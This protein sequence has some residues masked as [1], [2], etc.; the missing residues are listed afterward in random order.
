MHNTPLP[1]PTSSTVRPTPTWYSASNTPAFA[2]TSATKW[3]PSAPTQPTM[4]A[5]PVVAKAKPSNDGPRLPKRRKLDSEEEK[6]KDHTASAVSLSLFSDH[7]M[8]LYPDADAPFVD[9]MDVVS[10]LLPYHIFQHPKEDLE[11]VSN[12]KGKG[13]MTDELPDRDE[14]LGTKLAMKC[15]KRRQAL[16]E[17]F[18]RV[19][20]RAGKHNEP[21]DQAITLANAILDADRSATTYMEQQLNMA[22]SELDR[23]HKA[24][25]AASAHTHKGQSSSTT[26]PTFIT[27]PFGGNSSYPRGPPQGYPAYYNAYTYPYGQSNPYAPQA[28]T[29]TGKS[30]T[31]IANKTSSFVTTWNSASSST[32][33]QPPSQLGTNTGSIMPT[34]ITQPTQP[35]AAG[36][37][38]SPTRIPVSIPVASLPALQ[39]FGILP[40]PKAA[41]PPPTEPQPPAVLLGSTNGGTT[42]LLE[43]NVA[44]LQAS[45]MSGLAIILSGLMQRGHDGTNSRDTG[46]P[47]GG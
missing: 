21:H 42:L 18:R 24:Q 19:R 3:S 44:L 26:T 5:Q 22:R 4:S 7:I 31:A 13:R 45:Q 9:H 15:W 17:R 34:R 35:Q 33:A 47:A 12:I 23:L 27:H 2:S 6:I 30:S 39:A 10:R 1:P 37:A 29:N 25:R 46:K 16:Q 40:V 32:S 28:S 41:L 20:I 36:N 14:I 43:I 8:A 38:A 11:T